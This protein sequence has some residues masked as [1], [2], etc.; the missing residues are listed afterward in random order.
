MFV[1]TTGNNQTFFDITSSDIERGE[2]TFDLPTDISM[3]I[4]SVGGSVSGGSDIGESEAVGI[5]LPPG[6]VHII[7]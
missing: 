7:I 5:H 4:C 3:A 6:N 2:V 1:I